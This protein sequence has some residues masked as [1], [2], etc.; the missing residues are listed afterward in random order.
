VSATKIAGTSYAGHALAQLSAWPS[1]VARQAD[2][3][4]G[5]GVGTRAGQVLHFHNEDHVALCLTRPVIDRFR[6]VLSPAGIDVIPDADWIGIHLETP[7]DITLLV[8][9]VSVAIKANLPDPPH[10]PFHRMTPCGSSTVR[11]A[12]RS[13]HQPD[14]PRCPPQT[15]RQGFDRHP[16]P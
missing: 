13:P 4:L 2:C 10:A 5:I 12:R 9:L 11:D 14:A 1:V 8:T 16:N 7:T 3:G 6:D 15:A